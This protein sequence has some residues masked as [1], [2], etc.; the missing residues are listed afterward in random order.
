MRENINEIED[1]IQNPTKLSRH[2]VEIVNKKKQKYDSL[3][4]S[5]GF[6]ENISIN[7]KLRLKYLNGYKEICGFLK[8]FQVNGEGIVEL[9]KEFERIADKTAINNL[10]LAYAYLNEKN[11]SPPIIT[12]DD[13]KLLYFNRLYNKKISTKAFNNKYGHYALNP[14]ELSAKRFSEY[15]HN[16]LLGMAQHSKNFV[17]KKHTELK[18]YIA[19]E[20]SKN[21]F[22][23][24]SALR[25]E[26]KYHA[27]YIIHDLR[28]ELLKLEKRKN[29]ENI[30]NL[31]YR[32]VHNLIK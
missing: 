32:E 10:L 20:N 16:E 19:F 12:K 5:K 3:L 15:T 8:T 26:L 18:D 23:I 1:F 6:F 7:V 28:F 11:K 4:R 21:L 22:P 31:S 17:L 25:E 9:F 30:F 13:E 24:Y 27:L 2:L 29:I 14:F